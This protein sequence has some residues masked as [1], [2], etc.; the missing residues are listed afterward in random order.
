MS[1]GNLFVDLPKVGT[2]ELD[3]SINEEHDFDTRISTNPTEDGVEH[4]DNIILLPVVL[5][6]TAR[7]SDASMIPLVPSFGSK[8]IDAYN[9]LVELQTSKTLIDVTTGI[10]TYVNMF[11]KR[12]AVPRQSTDGNSLR[13]EMTF[14]ELLIVGDN[15]ENNRELIAADIIHT[16]LP[17]NNAN[18]VQKVAL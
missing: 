8:S 9:A 15:S 11:V 16:A 4:A 6:M 13:F 2:I 5:S 12:I 14:Q 3:A 7:V 10:R 17:E 1:F 18:V